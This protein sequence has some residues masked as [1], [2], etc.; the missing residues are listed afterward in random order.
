MSRPETTAP[1]ELFYNESE[2]RKY[3]S[4]SRMIKIQEE[5]TTRAMEMLGLP[6]RPCYILDIGCGSGLSGQGLEEAGHYWGGC[7]ISSSMFRVPA[8]QN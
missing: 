1:P 6:N 4:S 5:I 8:A 7:D 3:D 2:A